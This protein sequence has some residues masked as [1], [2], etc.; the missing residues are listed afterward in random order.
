MLRDDLYL[1]GGEFS[2]PLTRFYVSIG[3]LSV[4][5][6]KEAVWALELFWILWKRKVSALFPGGLQEFS[7]CSDWAWG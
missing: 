3:K 4:P 5:I 7:W 2:I 1:Y 6:E